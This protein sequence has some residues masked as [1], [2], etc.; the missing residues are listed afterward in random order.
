MIEVTVNGIPLSSLGL[1]VKRAD[2]PPLP[3][4]RDNSVEL[5]ERDGE[6]DFG[7]RYKPRIFNLECI[8]MADD[9]SIDYHQRVAKIAALF[10]AKNGDMEFTFN[11]RPG[12][13]YMA[14]YAGTMPVEKIIFDGN[15][16]IPLKMHDPFPES[17]TEIVVTKTITQSPELISISNNGEVNSYPVIVLKNSGTNTINGFTLTNEY[18]VE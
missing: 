16:T 11:F 4:T 8:L 18:E 9:A 13:R 12:V 1:A 14:R 2:I 10:N 17:V 6:V 15:L 3:E 7:A 5:A